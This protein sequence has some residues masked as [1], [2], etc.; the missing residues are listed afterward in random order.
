[1]EQNEH[2]RLMPSAAGITVKCAGSVQAQEKY[3]QEE[4]DS[5][6]EGTAVHWVIASVL[7]SYSNG[8]LRTVNDYLGKTAPNGIMITEEMTEA[9]YEYVYDVLKLCNTFGIL[10][11]LQVERR[12]K[13]GVIHA[14]NWGTPDATAFHPATNTLY[15]WDF[16]YGHLYVDVYE[17][18]QLLNYAIILTNGMRDDTKIVM[19]IIQP[20]CFSAEPV[21]EWS[22]TVGELRPYRNR[23]EM[24]FIEALSEH[25]TINSGSHCKYCSARRACKA[26]LRSSEAS[27]D[28]A[29]NLTDG[30]RELSDEDLGTLLNKLTRALES[31]ELIKSG[32][33][34]AATCRLKIGKHILG[35]Q[36]KEKKGR[37]IWKKSPAEIIELGK[38]FGI[39]LKKPDSVI[40]P[41]QAADKGIDGAVID[42]YS[43]TPSKGLKLDKDDGTKAKQV[44]TQPRG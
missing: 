4:T 2:A 25:P 8:P 6:K 16:K 7:D 31:I 35:W 15:L 1:M 29:L 21:R 33:E 41:K 5:T 14:D 23:L 27:M 42:A 13:A 32:I 37:T 34:E 22:I 40:T 12:T 3:P 43:N 36:L 10:S 26:A 9:A 44:F 28:F 38:M 17:C 39:D 19:R 30:I 11:T 18:W 24:A 20:R